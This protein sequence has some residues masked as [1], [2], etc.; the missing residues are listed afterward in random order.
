MANIGLDR[1]GLAWAAGF[2]DGEGNIYYSNK[3]KKRSPRLILQ[4]AQVRIEPLEKFQSVFNRGTINGPYKPK[5][6]KRQPYYAYRIEGFSNVQFVCAAMWKFL[7]EPKKED[8]IKMLQQYLQFL[9]DPRCFYGHPLKQGKSNRL[10]CSICQSAGA[11]IGSAK[12]WSK[13]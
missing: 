11:K 4:I 12:R 8:Y 9:E 5:S 3:N 13:I 7:N 10:I 6:I 2:F 1:E